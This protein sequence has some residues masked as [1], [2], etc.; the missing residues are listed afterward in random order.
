MIPENGVEDRRGSF[1][2]T[3]TRA[4]FLGRNGSELVVEGPERGTAPGGS[5]E[6]PCIVQR[7]LTSDH[8]QWPQG[9][10]SDQ[11]RDDR[12]DANQGSNL[13]WRG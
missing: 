13:G 5:R 8:R 10:A 6:P 12:G 11:S 1:R 9:H 7:A 4:T 2:I 3:A